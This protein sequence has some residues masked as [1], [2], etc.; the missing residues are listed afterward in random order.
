MSGTPV[1]SIQD[2]PS[3]PDCGCGDV[4]APE[5]EQQTPPAQGDYEL[6]GAVS[7]VHDPSIAKEGKNYYVFSTGPG[8]ALRISP[9]RVNWQP[10]IRVFDPVPSWTRLTIPGSNDFY[11]APDIS[12][13]NHKWHLYYAV[14][15][16]GKNRSAIGLATNTTLDP[17]GK[18]Y[19][20]VDEGPVFQSYPKDNYNAIDPNISFDEKGEPW[21]SF[22]SFWSGIKLL[23]IESATGKPE[24]PDDPPI[25]IAGRPH[26]GGQ[27]GAIEAPFI[28]R[29]G[30]YFFLFASFDFCCRGVNS[31]YNI[32]VGRASK[33]TG[34]YLDEDGKSMA[35]GGGSVVLATTGRWHGPGGSSF[36]KDG[37]NDFL[38]YHTYDGNENGVPKLRIDPV[39][40]DKAGWPRD[41]ALDSLR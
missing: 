21:L 24:R 29:H 36:L 7:F 10:A 37:R 11:W 4:P 6:K 9:D 33:I 22:G 41:H 32:R 12:F 14:S 34:P 23:K 15:T 1:N 39:T 35:D 27:P 30:R 8:I 28:V 13:F 26:T 19:K 2:V 38:V 20:W 40:W 31:T 3:K 16:F 5:S 17:K 18:D 25:A